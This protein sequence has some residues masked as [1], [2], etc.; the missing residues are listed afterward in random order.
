VS[1]RIVHL[2]LGSNLPSVAGDR[3]ATL[4]EAV[5]RLEGDARGLRIVQRST[6]YETPPVPAGQPAYLNAAIAVETALTLPDILTIAQAVERSLGRERSAGERWGPRTIDIDILLDG[7]SVFRAGGPLAGS[8]F[9]SGSGSGSGSGFGYGESDGLS[10]TVPHPR[11][12]ERL[13]VLVPLAE[14]APD[15]LVPPA[16]TP[17]EHLLARATASAGEAARQ[18]IRPIGPLVG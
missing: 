11:L 5:R 15:A 4:V 9:G 7:E 2:A 3:M 18:A 17:V 10:L 16:G 12:A 13:F 14:I 8:G 6:V 1:R